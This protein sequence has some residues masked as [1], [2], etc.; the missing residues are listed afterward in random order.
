M[1]YKVA[2]VSDQ[3]TQTEF[4]HDDPEPPAQ[5]I[6]LKYQKYFQNSETLELK[7]RGDLGGI[8]LRG[9]VLG[10]TAHWERRWTSMIF[11]GPFD[12]HIRN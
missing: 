2:T 7:V 5:V 9:V 1:S 3:D 4:R 6:L 11:K 12:G 10:C 8:S